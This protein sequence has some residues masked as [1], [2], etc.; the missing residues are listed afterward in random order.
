[1]ANPSGLLQGAIMMLNHLN[2][3]DKAELI[4]NAWLKTIES[5][6][7][8]A[9]IYTKAESVEKCTTTSFTNHLIGFLGEKPLKL[10]AAHYVTGKKSDST[11]KATLT[12]SEASKKIKQS[13]HG[14]DIFIKHF[15]DDIQNFGSQIQ[16]SGHGDLALQMI[17][18]RGLSVWPSCNRDDLSGNFW[19]CRFFSE[20]EITYDNIL[21]VLTDLH[22][23]G[24]TILKTENLNHFN[25]SEGYSK[26]QGQ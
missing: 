5:G 8:T 26:A 7:H 4:Q 15:T 22:K 6:Y 10:K 12:I 9:D 17:S 13:L 3:Q 20:K 18:T 19:R 1:M 11:K 23:K 25:G 24:F 2:M 21:T 16:A 14:V